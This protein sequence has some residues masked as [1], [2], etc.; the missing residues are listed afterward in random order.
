MMLLA[1]I[2]VIAAAILPSTPSEGHRWLQG[3]VFEYRRTQ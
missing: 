1:V 3:S 2:A